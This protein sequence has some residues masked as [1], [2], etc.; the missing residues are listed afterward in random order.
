[1]AAEESDRPSLVG[2]AERYGWRRFTFPGFKVWFL[3]Y[4]F[5]DADP[6]D[7]LADWPAGAD[8]AAIAGFLDG[9]DGHFALICEL[10]HSIVMAVD[11][12][13]SIPLYFT[14]GSGGTQVS[15]HS[16]ALRR[17]ANITQINPDAALAVAMAGY[18]IG[19]RT[20]YRGL[21]Q[22]GPGEFLNCETGSAPR[23]V[24]Y[25][26]YR[27]W[28]VREEEEGVFRSRFAEMHMSLIERMVS[29]AG[30]RVIALPLSAGRDSRAIV[31]ALAELGAKNVI[32]FAYGLPGNYEAAASKKIAKKLGYEWHFVPSTHAGQRRFWN[33]DLNAEFQEIADSNCST[34][35]VHDL[36]VINELLRRGVID[37]SAI[38]VNGNSGDYITGL[39]IQPPVSEDLSG[40]TRQQCADAIVETMLKKHYRLWGALETKENDLVLARQLHSELEALDLDADAFR[41]PHG[42]YE[43][44]ELQDRQAKYVISRQRVYEFLGLEWRLP[45][46]SRDYLDFF[47][48]V[49]LDLKRRQRLYARALEEQNWGGVWQ[50]PE[51]DFPQHV[52]PAW[53]RF[54]V[55]PLS[56]AMCAPFGRDR[57]HSF[58]RRFLGYWMD[59][60]ALQ[61]I[62]PYS[63]VARDTRGARHLVS[64]HT[65][66][67]LR[68][69]GLGWAGQPL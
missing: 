64:W 42:L 29:Q 55:R 41:H 59:L 34:T 22:L 26:Q 25:Y 38:I 17:S 62:Q 48:A 52:S 56:M 4:L 19:T 50:G 30:E 10:P 46:W 43:Y 31:S 68:R 28:R 14:S 7:A 13:R 23:R 21:E 33:S 6:R 36:P 66:A 65:E 47:E 69:K 60:F 2:L 45:L 18:T 58:E 12:I 9:L 39:H 8:D 5:N 51:W 44:L 3:G 57:W 24:R 32:C 37:R 35:V 49:P 53:M 67:Y 11:P 27:P 54:L 16:E 20:L 40:L 63:R 61:A 1:M 15:A